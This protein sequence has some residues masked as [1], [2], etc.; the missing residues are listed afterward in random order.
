[1]KNTLSIGDTY[2][3]LGN[4]RYLKGE[5]DDAIELYNKALAEN[6]RSVYALTS[7]GMCYTKKHD[8]D[9]ALIDFNK[10]VQI[11][12]TYSSA[13]YYRGN[14]YL[15]KG[16]LDKALSDYNQALKPTD[17]YALLQRGDVLYKLKSYALAIVDYTNLLKLYN[18]ADYYVKRGDAYYAAGNYTK[19]NAD[20]ATAKSLGQNVNN[21]S[22]ENSADKKTWTI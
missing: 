9:L 12:P 10:A 2:V 11:L 3:K 16:M 20:Y 7:R 14:L 18:S 13:F 21:S 8:L 1:M 4:D 6:P 15:E 22:K 17:P 19:A 5:F